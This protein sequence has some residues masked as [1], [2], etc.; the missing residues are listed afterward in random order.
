MHYSWQDITASVTNKNTA[1]QD[2]YVA[3]KLN[4]WLEQIVV[5][6]RGP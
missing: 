3:I 1:F 4:F 6:Q 2:V 5:A